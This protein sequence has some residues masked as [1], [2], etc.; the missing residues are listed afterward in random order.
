MKIDIGIIGAMVSE[1]EGLVS[2]L[3][4]VREEVVGSVKFYLG[5][6][7]GKKI[8]VTRCGIG[9]VF[10]AIATEAMIIAYSPR[11]IV[12][13]GVGGAVAAGLGTTDVVIADKLVQHDMDT[14]S[15]GDPK[16]LVSG[17]NKIYFDADPRAVKIIKTAAEEKGINAVLGTVASGDKFIAAKEDKERLFAEFGASACEMEGGAVAHVAFVNNTPF[18]VIRAI[19]DSADGEA[20]M[21][22]PTF[23]PIAAKIS[24]ELTLSLIKEY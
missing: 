19:S 1:V 6:L 16:G 8:A 13:T 10:A 22:Y 9:K 14:S 7:H 17:I 18:A 4:D 24:A 11:L 15:I 12:N 5:E 3:A 20:T 23:M 2:A 21:D